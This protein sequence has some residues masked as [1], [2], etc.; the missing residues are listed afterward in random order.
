MGNADEFS[1]FYNFTILL[2]QNRAMKA[3]FA[4]LYLSVLVVI[5][6]GCSHTAKSY[7][8]H[9]DVN[10]PDREKFVGKVLLFPTDIVIKE[11][12]PGGV[13]EDMP[14]W[15]TMTNQLMIK[16]LGKY[17]SSNLDIRSIAFQSEKNAAIIR[18]HIA[19]LKRT[20]RSIRKHT[21]GWNNWPHKVARFDY[22]IGPG[23]SYFTRKKV[24]SAIIITG[25]QAIEVAR[26]NDSPTDINIYSR[27]Q[28]TFGALHLNVSLVDLHNGFILW[29]NMESFSGIDIRQAVEVRAVLVRFFESFPVSLFNDNS[30]H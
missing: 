14:A 16:E 11:I 6:S 28:L 24:D 13:I 18:D 8:F 30:G 22:E 17:L 3:G 15:T 19:L 23:L 12:F 9:Y 7:N 26:F 25:I 29:N 1:V 5:L 21:R 10:N 4:H 27:D 2:E 20:N